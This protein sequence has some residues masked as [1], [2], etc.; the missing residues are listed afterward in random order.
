MV[1]SSLRAT[2]VKSRVGTM[3]WRANTA[4]LRSGDAAARSRIV[5][6]MFW[7][8]RR[9]R[10][11]ML[12]V[13][14]SVADS[15]STAFSSASFTRGS[16]RRA[17]RNLS[18]PKRMGPESGDKSRQKG[19]PPPHIYQRI[20]VPMLGAYSLSVA[21]LKQLIYSQILDYFLN[22]QKLTKTQKAA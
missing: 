10:M 12:T 4:A 17:G 8:W 7:P 3:R 20:P 13:R 19:I 21:S 11:S 9:V 1:L 16:P 2:A 14:R 18:D 15:R 6:R 22:S 5:A